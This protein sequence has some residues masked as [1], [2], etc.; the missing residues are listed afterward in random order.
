MI[1]KPRTYRY[2][3]WLYV[4]LVSQH[5][6]EFTLPYEPRDPIGVVKVARVV[7]VGPMFQYGHTLMDKDEDE[8]S[9]HY[10]GLLCDVRSL[11]HC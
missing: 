7:C 1:A 5:D 3:S 11:G 10:R 2:R 8:E 6:R 9:K 4:N